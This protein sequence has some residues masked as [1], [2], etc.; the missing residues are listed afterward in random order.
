VTCCSPFVRTLGCQSRTARDGDRIR[1]CLSMLRGTFRACRVI[2]NHQQRHQNLGEEAHRIIQCMLL[3][4]AGESAAAL[5]HHHHRLTCVSLP[6]APIF[7][8]AY[9][10]ISSPSNVLWMP[11]WV[12]QHRRCGKASHALHAHVQVWTR[13][14]ESSY[15][16]V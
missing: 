15:G 6:V 9:N 4:P 1:G 11:R 10:S 3:S 5:P 16:A 2:S 13:T 14:P 8:S 7:C 12:K